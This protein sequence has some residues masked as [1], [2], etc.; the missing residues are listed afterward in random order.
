MTT[1]QVCDEDQRT[2]L[3]IIPEK[4]TLFYVRME[5]TDLGTP[6]IPTVRG[7]TV[8]FVNAAPFF[9][10]PV[11]TNLVINATLFF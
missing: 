4:E 7:N 9:S 8:K 10:L 11:A 6:F 1:A 3:V 5:L 2:L